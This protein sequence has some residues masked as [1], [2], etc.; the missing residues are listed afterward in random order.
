MTDLLTLLG[1]HQFFRARALSAR[2]PILTGTPL[3]V[4]VTSPQPPLVWDGSSSFLVARDLG[5]LGRTGWVP[6][7][8][9][10][11]GLADAL[12]TVTVGFGVHSGSFNPEIPSGER[13][14][15]I[16]EK[17]LYAFCQRGL[18]NSCILPPS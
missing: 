2:G 8:A 4:V 1:R 3:P 15:N 18:K 11:L 6:R 13:V 9:P 12:V 14:S 17:N 5:V 7:D 16:I 10:G